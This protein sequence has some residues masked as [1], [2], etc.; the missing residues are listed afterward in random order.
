MPNTS[1]SQRVRASV[2]LD[3]LTYLPNG[4]VGQSMVTSCDKLPGPA[5]KPQGV[6][7]SKSVTPTVTVT[8]CIRSDTSKIIKNGVH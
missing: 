8:F 6:L 1:T 5:K 2:G 7:M 4:N 3:I